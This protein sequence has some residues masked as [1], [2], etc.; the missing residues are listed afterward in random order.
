ML[1]LHMHHGHIVDPMMYS[2]VTNHM[3]HPSDQMKHLLTCLIL[4]VFS[5][6]KCRNCNHLLF[7]A[8]GSKSL[9]YQ[10]N[11]ATQHTLYGKQCR[12]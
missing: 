12:S 10:P 8:C 5:K 2:D 7:L 3:Y 9:S 6:K 4:V 11:Y 1:I